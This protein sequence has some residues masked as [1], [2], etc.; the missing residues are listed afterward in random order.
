MRPC[1]GLV[2][3]LLTGAFLGFLQE[4]LSKKLSFRGSSIWRVLKDPTLLGFLFWGTAHM[5]K[6]VTCEGEKMAV[7]QFR[8]RNITPYS[9]SVTHKEEHVFPQGKL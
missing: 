8:P 6:K 4:K 2:V 9:P 3:I 5:L 1:S 7:S